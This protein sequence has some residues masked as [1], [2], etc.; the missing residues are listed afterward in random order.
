MGRRGPWERGWAGRRKLV[1]FRLSSFSF[2]YSF[3]LLYQSLACHSR[4]AL[5]SPPKTRPLRRRQRKKC[6]EPCLLVLTTFFFSI[7]GKFFWTTD[8]SLQSSG[9]KYMNHSAVHSVGNKTIFSCSIAQLINTHVRRVKLVRIGARCPP[10]K[11][12]CS[13][14]FLNKSF[15]PHSSLHTPLPLTRNFYYVAFLY[16]TLQLTPHTL[17]PIT[18]LV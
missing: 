2:P 10:W 1:R 18:Y 11:I 6:S 5:A 14:K 7:L 4:L 9:C 13:K 16:I 8:S 17:W 12:S 15:S 3:A